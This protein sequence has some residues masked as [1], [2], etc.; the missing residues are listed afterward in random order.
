M[1]G[2]LISLDSKGHFFYPLF[3]D[4]PEIVKVYCEARKQRLQ[5]YC[6]FYPGVYL[7][8]EHHFEDFFFLLVGGSV[9]NQSLF[10]KIPGLVHG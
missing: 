10:V 1:A 6:S 7:E 3:R 8:V 5:I 4:D 2:G 9:L